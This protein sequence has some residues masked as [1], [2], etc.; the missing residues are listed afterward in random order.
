M[1]ISELDITKQLVKVIQDHLNEYLPEGYAIVPK[2]VI[3]DFPDVDKMPYSTC[4]YVHP[5]YSEAEELTTCS[6]E[7]NF[8][9]SCFVVCKRDT[10]TNL[11]EKY[12]AYYNAVYYLLRNNTS[13]EGTIDE[14]K[15]ISVDFYPAIEGNPDVRGSEI[16]LNTIFAKDFKGE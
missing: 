6:D 16:S 2:Q 1:M 10:Q 11:T 15:I 7:V 8:R 14:T 4:I 5:D 12:F 9:L 13:L 3:L